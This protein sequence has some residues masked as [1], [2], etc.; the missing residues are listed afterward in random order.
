MASELQARAWGLFGTCL[1]REPRERIELLDEACGDDLDLRREVES[2][3][4]AAEESGSFLERDPPATQ[5]SR[6]G[7]EPI[8]GRRIGPYRLLGLLSRGGMG[9]VY[10]AARRFGEFEKRVALKLLQPEMAEQEEIRW[11]FRTESRILAALDHPNIARFLDAG[12]EDG[13]HY[14]VIEYIEG[15]PLDEYCDAHKLST[16]ER[17]ELFRG[18][19]SAV[20]FAHQNTVVHRD[21]KP[22]N[23]LVTAGG[24][25]KLL[26]FGIAKLLNPD[27]FSRAAAPTV[28]RPYTPEY[29]SPE[30]VLGEPITTASDVYSLGVLL[31]QLL[32]G[33]PPYRFSSY[34]PGEVVRTVCEHEPEKPSVAV[35]RRQ[36]VSGA[37]GTRVLTPESVA[38]TRDGD[39]GRLRR[40]LAGDLDNI[41]LQALRKE[42]Q[43]RYASVEQLSEDL[44]RHLEGRPVSARGDSVVYRAGKFIRRHRFG[45]AAVAAA[46]LA[47]LAFGVV[48]AVQRARLAEALAG[49]E[50]VT[51]FLIDLFEVS[52]PL[53][54]GEQPLSAREILDRGKDKLATEL[55]QR[56]EVQARL[57]GAIGAIYGKLGEYDDAEQLLRRSLAVRRTHV[58][59]PDPG[60][61]SNLN[62]LGEVVRARGQY[63]EAEALLREALAMR[64]ALF[65]EGHSAVGESL[66][67]LA[68]LLRFRGDV[69]HAEQLYS[70]AIDIFRLGDDREN[71]ANT[72]NNLAR[73]HQGQGELDAAERLFREA[74][75]LRREVLT[76]DHALVANSLSNLA[77][78]L[79]EKGEHASAEP[80]YRESLA[81]LR[82][83]L[84]DRHPWVGFSLSALT[85]LLITV[86]EHAEAERQAREAA[87]ILRATLPEDHWRIRYAESM[88]GACLTALG[89]YEE[90]EP[91]LMAS[92]RSL[93]TQQGDGSPYVRKTLERLVDLYEAW[94]RP[95]RAAEYRSALEQ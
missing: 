3:L 36:E 56:P 41:A 8:E 25:P 55:H 23:I 71:L 78:L 45:V 50:L 65:G 39:P 1:G 61:A 48:M 93:K 91:I 59:A 6:R 64:R 7:Q 15:Q 5:P 52:D 34:L 42:P 87:V 75:A 24:V 11:R 88:R 20:Q 21:L 9:T 38:A 57:Q 76:P 68:S 30:Q 4:V 10:L 72:L 32:T 92:Y 16:R 79:Q 77:A 89:R 14:I 86:G 31:Y 69:D 83:K 17:L 90:A 37:Q 35:L 67:N 26:D 70:E 29:A 43:R 74:L 63:D 44:R 49:E 19:C 54:Q 22:A 53:A 28:L 13:Q 33:H 62:D 84:G 58:D 85:S 60:L 80:L 66:N 73:L 2:L 47:L 51:G 18:A 46:L 81:I 82:Q 27:L 40:R 12:T 95:D 94:G